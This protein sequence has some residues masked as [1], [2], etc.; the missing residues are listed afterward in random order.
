MVRSGG[1][2]QADG[3]SLPSYAR[4]APAVRAAA[5]WLPRGEALP[6]ADW[7][8]RHRMV[9]WVLAVHVPVLVLIA[10]LGSRPVE[11]VHVVLPL[12]ALLGLACLPRLS[13]R[14]RGLSASLGLLTGSALVVHLF[15][16]SSEAH[17]HYFVTVAII[18]LYQDWTVYVLA[19]GFVLLQHGVMASQPD[20]VA[21]PA[22]HLGL[23]AGARRRDPGRV[24]RAGALLARERDQ[25][26]PV[27]GDA[28]RAARR[29]QHR[30]R[31]GWPRP[32]A[33]GPTSSAP[34]RTSS[35]RR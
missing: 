13:R 2:G 5:D 4:P 31:R 3:M 1:S 14:L 7:A 34:C 12:G 19:V 18:A 15:D 9:C 20:G 17:F 28:G 10:A 16:G 24:G 26:P 8:W 22:R 27:R 6:D 11:V 33:S 32:T 21:V 25:P 30:R 29:P 35:A 23:G